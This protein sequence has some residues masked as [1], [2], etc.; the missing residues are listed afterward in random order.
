M[1]SFEQ[2]KISQ[3]DDTRSFEYRVT[4][5]GS[6]VIA[7]PAS[8][9]NKKNKRKKKNSKRSKNRKIGESDSSRLP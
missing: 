6:T 5:V 3:A 7:T 9:K 1:E 4:D 2:V 8:K